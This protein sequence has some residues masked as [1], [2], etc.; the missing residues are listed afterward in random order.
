MNNGLA[1]SAEGSS[2]LLLSFVGIGKGKDN[3]VLPAASEG[4]SFKDLVR[5][6]IKSSKQSHP[7]ITD[8]KRQREIGSEHLEQRVE[9]HGW[10]SSLSP[11]KAT[12]AKDRLQALVDDGSLNIKELDDMSEE[13]LSE[14]VEWLLAGA[15]DIFVPFDELEVAS[16]LLMDNMDGKIED[17]DL[18]NAGVDSVG[19]MQNFESD[20]KDENKPLS[21]ND[22]ISQISQAE[23]VD[24][25]TS[26]V[27]KLSKLINLDNLTSDEKAKL[28]TELKS[29]FSETLLNEPVVE[30]GQ[31]NNRDSKLINLLSALSKDEIVDLFASALKNIGKPELLQNN[32]KLKEVPKVILDALGVKLLGVESKLGEVENDITDGNV[33]KNL[34][35]ELDSLVGKRSSLHENITEKL[36]GESESKSLENNGLKKIVNDDSDNGFEFEEQTDNLELGEEL[37]SSSAKTKDG[38]F[39]SDNFGDI[40]DGDELS[41]N[42][43]HAHNSDAVVKVNDIKNQPIVERYVDTN[44]NI[45]KI[46]QAMKL[47]AKRGISTATLQL[48]PGDL[49]KIKLTI[50]VTGGTMNAS[51]K[52]ENA[53]ARNMLAAN[54]GHLRDTLTA[55][56]IKFG[57]F[58]ISYESGESQQ[59]TGE[60]FTN[61]FPRKRGGRRDVLAA[62]D[63]DAGGENEDIGVIGD[64]FVN[65]IA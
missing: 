2:Q 14:L 39:L 59:H 23:I 54:V 38:S 13:E 1:S 64:G 5:D 6:V 9:T 55:Q 42:V 15:G 47:S 21:K 4:G 65:M 10:N 30:N 8:E 50:S 33:A 46:S 40:L 12:V 22:F 19:F 44:Q 20:D 51:I 7:K 52:T 60:N 26:E 25:K 18:S 62:T 3:N 45:E 24:G 48:S 32:E 16:R 57:E 56:G 63:V 49:G 41:L 61:Q 31:G 11:E 35:A 37:Q 36:G 43:N 17:N 27:S 34:L 28:A 58:D 29:L 53:D